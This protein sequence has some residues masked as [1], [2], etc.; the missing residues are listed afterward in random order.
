[1]PNSPP[2]TSYLGGELSAGDA[3]ELIRAFLFFNNLTNSKN[4]YVKK[5]T[6]FALALSLFISTYSINITILNPKSQS[7]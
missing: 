6:I 1:M 4:Y 7:R 5:L 2:I 3:G